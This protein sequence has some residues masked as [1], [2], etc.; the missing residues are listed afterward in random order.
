MRNDLTDVTL[1]IDRS[2]SMVSM[3]TDAEGGINSFV[4]Y[5]LVRMREQASSGETIRNEFT[6]EER[7]Q[8]E[9]H[10]KN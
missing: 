6:P 10:T 5:K 7:K 1:V 4:A 3:R 9:Q 8:M 2:G